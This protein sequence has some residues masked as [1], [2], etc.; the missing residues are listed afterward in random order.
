MDT[1][2]PDLLLPEGMTLFA[3]GSLQ[4]SN[5]QN[6]DT[7]EYVCEVGTSAG[8]ATQT[9]A[10]EVQ[11]KWAT[12]ILILIF[13]VDKI[14]FVNNCYLKYYMYSDTYKFNDEFKIFA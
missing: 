9:H 7:A 13:R 5:V 2:A 3:N 12:C 8:M 4:V 14:V 6:L 1:R 10:I 11:C